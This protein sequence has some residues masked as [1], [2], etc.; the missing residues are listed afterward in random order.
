M[1]L[2]LRFCA[3]IITKH[4]FF[5]SPGVLK[6]VDGREKSMRNTFNMLV[7]SSLQAATSY[8]KSTE[9]QVPSSCW[10]WLC[11]Y[12]DGFFFL[13]WRS[14][15]FIAICGLRADR[16]IKNLRSSPTGSPTSHW[17]MPFI[18]SSYILFFKSLF[19]SQ[20]VFFF[21]FFYP[22]RHGMVSPPQIVRNKRLARVQKYNFISEKTNTNMVQR[23]KK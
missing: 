4:F 19:Q 11:W 5:F 14:W 17:P 16:R 21:F 7:L 13:F 18:P 6:R 15:S 2:T 22:S 12:V 3:T 1:A 23:Q 10:F 9:E 8:R 20:E